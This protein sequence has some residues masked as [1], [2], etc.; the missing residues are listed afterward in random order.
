M[1]NFSWTCPYCN[2]KCTITNSNFSGQTHIFNLSNKHKNK[3]GLLSEVIVCPNSDCAEIS[4]KAFLFKS[5]NAIYQEYKQPSNYST[6]HRWE[7]LPSSH[8]KPYPNYIPAAILEDYTEACMI[9][10]LSPK[11]SATL[12]RRCLQ[13]MIRNYWNISKNNLFEEIN[14]LEDKVDSQIWESLNAVREIGNIGAHMEKN[15]DLIIDVE[16]E[17]A[18]ILI[19]L[20]ELLFEEWYVARHEREIKLSKIIKI[21]DEKKLQKIS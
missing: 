4:I 15:I 17:E 7:L 5:E 1:S 8:A 19:Q 6:I 12:S 3:V 2:H 16:P 9:S 14:A 10:D 18:K 13:G 20:L 21:K 11:A